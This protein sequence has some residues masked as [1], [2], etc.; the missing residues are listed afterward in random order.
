MLTVKTVLKKGNKFVSIEQWTGKVD[1]P[2]Y[3]EGA[4]IV[5]LNGK[6]ILDESLWDDINY[7]WPYIANGFIDI[8]E[9]KDF[10]TGFPDQPITFSVKHIS[11]T[12]LQL[13]IFAED[14]EFVNVKIRKEEYLSEMTRAAKDFFIRLYEISPESE[15]DFNHYMD[16]LNNV[17]HKLTSM[18][19]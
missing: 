16:L 9:G 18:G 10:Q 15:Q 4:L 1:D 7:F 17:E 5:T 13:H 19:T 2:E 6:I 3:I 11:K 8:L 14:K 12:W